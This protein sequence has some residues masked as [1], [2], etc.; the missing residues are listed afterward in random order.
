MLFKVKKIDHDWELTRD[1]IAGGEPPTAK[2]L[3][4]EGRYF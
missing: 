4:I 3:E 1:V 2:A